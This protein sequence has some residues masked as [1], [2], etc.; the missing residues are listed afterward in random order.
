MP[1]R[2]KIGGAMRQQVARTYGRTCHLCGYGISP[3]HFTADHLK[4]V[5]AGGSTI[6]SNLRPC[7]RGCNSYRGARP[8]TEE[9]RAECRTRYKLLNPHLADIGK[10]AATSDL[11]P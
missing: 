6:L 1:Y 10:R 9:L 11:S 3:A 8:L 4:S 5:R 2:E 7:H